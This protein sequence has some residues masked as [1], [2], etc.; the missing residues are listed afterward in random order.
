LVANSERSPEDLLVILPRRAAVLAAVVTAADPAAR[1]FHICGRADRTG[2]VAMGCVEMLVHADDILQA[3]GRS[4]QPPDDLCRRVVARLF[5][6]APTDVDGWSALR[7]LVGRIDLPGQPRVAS[8]W[9][10]FAAPVAEWDGEIKTMESYL[11]VG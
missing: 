1:G 6:W 7:W 9:A 10:W 3:F 8:N 5:P 4:L 2:F 11:P